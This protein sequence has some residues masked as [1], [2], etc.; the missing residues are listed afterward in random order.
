M[1]PSTNAAP[2]FDGEEDLGG[3]RVHGPQR[4]AQ[5]VPGRHGAQQPHLVAARRHV[6]HAHAHRERVRHLRPGRRFSIATA[7]SL[8]LSPPWVTPLNTIATTV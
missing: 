1:K 7:L 8:L 2:T 6:V 5:R 3:G 4:Q